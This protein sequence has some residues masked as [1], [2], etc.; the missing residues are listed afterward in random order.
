[1]NIWPSPSPDGTCEVSIEYELENENVTLYD[2]VLSIPLPYVHLL[3]P[4]PRLDLILYPSTGSYPTVSSH[5]GDWALDPST[6]SLAWSIPVVSPSD[7]SRTGSMIFSVG[8]DDAGVFFPVNVTFNG[9]GSLAG[10]AVRRAEKTGGGG[11]GQGEEVAYS[12]DAIV[13]VEEYLVV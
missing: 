2:V 3:S 12:M 13:A 1:M 4:S 7:E 6:H 5:T 8:G 11:E 10:I 9:Q